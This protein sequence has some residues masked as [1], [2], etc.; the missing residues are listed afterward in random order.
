MSFCASP[1]R[2]NNLATRLIGGE[3]I[4][5][6][7]RSG[8]GELSAIYSLNELGTVIWELIDGKTAVS[9]MV[10]RICTEFEV[11]REVATSDVEEYLECLEDSGLIRGSSE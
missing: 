8:V 3:T 2:E 9:R 10:D 7:V 1:E 6:P 5:V 4:V 11:S